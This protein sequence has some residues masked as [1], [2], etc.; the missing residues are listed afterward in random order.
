MRR[1]MA[2]AGWPAALAVT[3]PSEPRLISAPGGTSMGAPPSDNTGKPVGV[4]IW[5]WGETS[6]IPARV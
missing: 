2:C 3:V 5:P 6:K 4:S 1:P